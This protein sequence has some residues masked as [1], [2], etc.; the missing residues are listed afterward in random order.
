LQ[1]VQ[2]AASRYLRNARAA[3]L[4]NAMFYMNDHSARKWE[5]SNDRYTGQIPW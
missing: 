2:S 4:D 3:N 5:S 1:T